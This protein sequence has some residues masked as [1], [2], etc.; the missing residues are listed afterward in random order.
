MIWQERLQ[1]HQLEIME[2]ILDQVL[3][4]IKTLIIVDILIISQVIPQVIILINNNHQTIE[5][6]PVQM[7]GKIKS[8]ENK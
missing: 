6:I 4:D 3:V 7:D 1:V 5:G 2:A 8:I